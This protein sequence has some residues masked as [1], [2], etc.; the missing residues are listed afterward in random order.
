MHSTF[1]LY[2]DAAKLVR[3]SGGVLFPTYYG[4]PIDQGGLDQ[5]TVDVVP[6]P[7]RGP[8]VVTSI[9][10]LPFT[11][12]VPGPPFRIDRVS[13]RA[14]GN[15][16]QYEPFLAQS[17]DRLQQDF[18]YTLPYPILI[19]PGGSCYIRNFVT[20]AS[21]IEP[22]SSEIVL[23]GF[24]TD[25][26]G[27]RAIARNG[28]PWVIPFVH[29]HADTQRQDIQT[30]RQMISDVVEMGYITTNYQSIN[31][32]APPNLLLNARIRGVEIA[33]GNRAF[34][35]AGAL[36]F[37]QESGSTLLAKCQAGDAFTLRTVST[38]APIGDDEAFMC[39][40]WTRRIYRQPNMQCN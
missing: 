12:I 11:Q 16:L 14:G 39:N 9:Q 27:A 36:G 17:F 31:F 2:K 23:S 35:V 32:P 28:Q 22:E 34:N 29:N 37:L 21:G 19:P 26:R 30:E 3:D 18:G 7:D 40:L 1:N 4:A 5:A 24:H 10:G 6:A 33:Q 15:E 25:A 13:I 8:F 20:G 38:A